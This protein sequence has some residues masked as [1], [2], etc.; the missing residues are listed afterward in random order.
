MH[1][2]KTFIKVESATKMAARSTYQQMQ[3]GPYDSIFTD[4]DW[5]SNSLKAYTMVNFSFMAKAIFFL[6][7][8]C[9]WNVE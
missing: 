1:K 2:I 6:I 4:K 5:F 7:Y 8:S 9:Q 3:K